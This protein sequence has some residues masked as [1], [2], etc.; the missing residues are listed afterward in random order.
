MNKLKNIEKTQ[1]FNNCF[2]LNFLIEILIK[3]IF[4]YYYIIK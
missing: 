4:Y 3:E 2:I 1:L